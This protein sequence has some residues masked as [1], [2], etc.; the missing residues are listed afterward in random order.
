MI[1]RHTHGVT[2]KQLPHLWWLSPQLQSRFFQGLFPFWEHPS[3]RNAV[4]GVTANALKEE[5][6]G[7]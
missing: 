4:S 5:T 3:L 1:V 7:N 6:R 2:I